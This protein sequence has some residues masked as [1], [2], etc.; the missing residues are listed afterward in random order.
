VKALL[1]FFLF[2]GMKPS[3]DEGNEYSVK[4]MFIYNF[5]KYIDWSQ[6]GN[7]KT[8]RIGIVG[9]SELLEALELIATQKKIDNKQI[10]VKK[11]TDDD[12]TSYQ[13][14]F[15]AKTELSKIEELSKKFMGK[16]VL[17][18]S[19]ECRHSERSATINLVTTDNKVRFEIN[20]STARNAGLKISSALTNLA[21][22]VNP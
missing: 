19:E 8:F 16:G 10:E 5:T 4:A 7:T 20:Q 12:N 17:I 1:L 21:I 11:I 22:V 15:I 3:S 18:I 6:S 13:I 9:K 14:V 2:T